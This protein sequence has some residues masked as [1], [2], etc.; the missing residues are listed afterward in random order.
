VIRAALIGAAALIVWER[1]VALK[2][3]GPRV[4]KPTERDWTKSKAEAFLR[5][6]A[7]TC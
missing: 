4:R 1:G 5:V 6:V 7:E 2:P 3:G